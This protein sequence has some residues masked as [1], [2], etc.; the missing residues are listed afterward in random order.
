MRGKL[1]AHTDKCSK[2]VVFVT[3]LQTR[4]HTHTHEKHNKTNKHETV[5]WWWSVR[6]CVVLAARCVRRC[7]R[8]A[9]V[10]VRRVDD[11]CLGMCALVGGRC[12]GKVRTYKVNPSLQGS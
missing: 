12:A 11:A 9:C 6:I 7:T 1:V 3:S 8:S 10:G 5:P 2:E 4:I